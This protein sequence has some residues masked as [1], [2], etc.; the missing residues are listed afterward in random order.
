MNEDTVKFDPA[1]QRAKIHEILDIVL[2]GNGFNKRKS[3][4]TGDLQTV[5]FEFTGHTAEIQVLLYPNGWHA[6]RRRCSE[7]N[8]DTDKPISEVTMKALEYGV[9]A[10]LEGKEV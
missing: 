8:F 7:F 10:A 4:D 1:V 2:D 6:E 3:P 5:F 9:R